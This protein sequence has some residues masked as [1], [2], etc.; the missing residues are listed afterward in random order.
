M[1]TTITAWLCLAAGAS[2]A[3]DPSSEYNE[4]DLWDSE[5]WNAS[6]L[7]R[8][9]CDGLRP[10]E[11]CSAAAE[12]AFLST[13]AEVRRDRPRLIITLANGRSV[14]FDDCL[15]LGG[16]TY[17]GAIDPLRYHLVMYAYEETD[18]YLVNTDT[19]WQAR[20]DA[21]P[22]V[23]PGGEWIAT[24]RPDLERGDL[25]NRVQVWAV[26]RDTLCL[27]YTLDGREA[28][29]PDTSVSR[30]RPLH[31]RWLDAST[32]AFDVRVQRRDR[33]R[34]FPGDAMAVRHS[35]NGWSMVG[36]VG[37]EPSH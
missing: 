36:A 1:R 34:I 3:A 35:R 19:G 26:V 2:L 6:P 17:L 10:W 37:P 29:H 32:L 5:G 12:S 20:V 9:L 23:S 21:F 18:Y 27:D 15:G 16:Y 24:A 33:W 4:S 28:A 22:V 11:R 8:Q 7:I 25:P 31:P 13:H 14:V 30:W